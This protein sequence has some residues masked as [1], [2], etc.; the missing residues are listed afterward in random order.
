MRASGCTEGKAHTH[1]W[2]LD[3]YG[4]ANEV[5]FSP[6]AENECLEFLP[7]TPNILLQVRGQLDE[8]WGG[9]KRSPFKNVDK[10]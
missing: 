9:P 3:T 7:R 10:G 1:V 8:T 4:G 2:S 6:Q 5:A